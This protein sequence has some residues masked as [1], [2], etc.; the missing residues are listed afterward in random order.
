MVSALLVLVTAGVLTFGSVSASA[1]GGPGIVTGY[2]QLSGWV[3]DGFTSDIPK[4]ASGVNVVVQAVR[5]TDNGIYTRYSTD[6]V[7]WYGWKGDGRSKAS[8]T[9]FFT[10][11]RFVMTVIGT[12]NYSY[13][14]TSTDGINWSGW[15]GDG[16]MVFDVAKYALYGNKVV[17]SYVSTG[18]QI[19]YRISN[20]G[21]ASWS[22][23]TN[24]DGFA[25]GSP[26]V[27]IKQFGATSQ[28]LVV[29]AVRGTDNRIYLNVSQDGGTSFSGWTANGATTQGIDGSNYGFLTRGTD[30]VA[31]VMQ[32]DSNSTKANLGWASI[33]N[34]Q[35]QDFKVNFIPQLSQGT[36]SFVNT[37]SSIEVRPIVASIS[38]TG[39][40]ISSN[41]KF[42]EGFSSSRVFSSSFYRN[43]DN[44]E[45]LVTIVRG[46]DGRIYT[47]T[48]EILYAA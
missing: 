7:N 19:F 35:G 44:K 29:L 17:Q 9:L 42:K 4:V 22:S 6:G 31:Y 12:D 25:V 3:G 2:N 10:G 14:N 11:S 28:N 32:V 13:T 18:N 45:L 20:D 21:G 38:S 41:I 47:R 1:A 23:W 48:L 37:D 16:L 36:F 43:S 40:V 15:K 30:A 26:A 8:P 34:E 24:T 39:V 46:T 27:V 5:G 33:K